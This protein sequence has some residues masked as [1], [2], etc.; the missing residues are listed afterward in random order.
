VK[1]V[2]LPLIAVQSTISGRKAIFHATDEDVIVEAP[3]K[4]VQQ[5]TA[6]CDGTRTFEEVVKRLEKEWDSEAVRGLLE[7]LR[8]KKVLVEA[9]QLSE[10]T[11]KVV[12]N[13]SRFPSYITDANAVEFA[14]R[15]NERHRQ[16][17]SKIIY[18]AQVGPLGSL[19]SQRQSTRSFSSAPVTFQ[20]IVNMLWSAYGAI[21][22]QEDGYSRRTVPSA[23]ALYPLVISI[24]LFKQT[25]DLQPAVYS[26]YLGHPS[27]VGFNFVS[28][29]VLRFSRSFLN[30]I[31]LEGAHGVIVISG[32]FR[33]TGEKYGNRSM[34]YVSL[35]A[36]H[37]AQNV[38]LAAVEQ[39]VAT[40][41]IGGFV[42]KLLA[43]AINLPKHHYPLTTVVFGCKEEET[44]AKISGPK[45]EIQWNIPVND[46]YRPPFAIASA[47]MSAGRSWSHGRD[48]SPVLAH[49]KAVAEAKEWAACGCL[50]N[51]LVRSR[52]VDLETAIDPRRMIKF[53][54]TQYRLRRFPFQP[55]DEKTKYA[56]TEGH[57]EETG[58]AVHILAD[59]VYFP[60]LPKTPYYAYANSSGVAAHPDRQKAV[61][62]SALELIERDSFTIAYLTQLEF[63][64]VREQT[65]PQSIRK[66]VQELRKAGFRVWIKDHS[67][68]LAP[69]ACVLAQG[70][71]FTC[72]L[73]ASCASFDIEHAVDHALMEVE[74][75]ILA[76][77][78]NGPA[79]RIKPSEVVWPLDHGMLYGQRQYFHHAD[80]LI[81]GQN[82]IAFR[83][84]G[85]SVAGSWQELLDRFATK[86]WRLFTIPLYLSDEYGGNG[87][88]HIIRSVVPGMVPMTFGYKQEPAGMERI[89]AIAKEFGKKRLSCRELTKF[90]HP[91]A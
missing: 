21:D 28:N 75:S 83:D 2:F 62:T 54:P 24:A 50:P 35:E 81:R 16:G 25:D 48:A 63:S 33:I 55:L 23:G 3:S 84:I 10:E 19:L 5:F 80:F 34:L 59:L 51:K 11:W 29:E 68:D 8:R 45:L 31:M 76:R 40:V 64:T 86:G 14:H 17:P 88:L 47:R 69:V 53:H 36:G 91:F 74:A 15:A 38:H 66:R 60:Y 79:A 67:L 87:D 37:A 90:P 13:P 85:R 9:R 46:R 44:K 39:G 82:L 49:T 70:K 42:E 58:S 56:W 57:D 26:V 1:R 61:E 22:S 27:S 73:C 30:P 20:S 89:Y 72:T 32:S 12:E 71:E 18:P 65:L 4:L 41:E 78:Q 43:K 77:L 52:F 7:S 6:L